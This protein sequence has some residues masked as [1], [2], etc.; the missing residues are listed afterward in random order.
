MDRY[1]SFYQ[2]LKEYKAA[3]LHKQ[4]ASKNRLVQQFDKLLNTTSDY[5]ELQKR[6]KLT[7]ANRKQLLTFLDQPA[8]PLHNNSAERGARRVVRKRDISLHTSSDQGTIVRDSFL[9][10]IETAR[11]L[12]VNVFDYINRRVRQEHIEQPLD[13]LVAKMYLA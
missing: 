3:D 13:T 1:W 2:Q 10:V 7:Y 8:I 5:G 4:K 11:K 9:S 12:G 6:M